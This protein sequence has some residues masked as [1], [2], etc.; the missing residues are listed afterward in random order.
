MHHKN[1]K[2]PPSFNAVNEA[3]IVV[4]YITAIL[5]V[6]ATQHQNWTF[7]PMFIFSEVPCLYTARWLVCT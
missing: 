3:N 7:W 1:W 5:L 6:C 4:S 2:S